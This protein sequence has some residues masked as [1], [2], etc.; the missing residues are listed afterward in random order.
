MVTLCLSVCLKDI[1]SGFIHISRL[2]PSANRDKQFVFNSVFEGSQ[3]FQYSKKSVSARGSGSSSKSRPFITF[4][5]GS[6]RVTQTSP[7]RARACSVSGSSQTKQPAFFF[8]STS[9]ANTSNPDCLNLRPAV[10]LNIADC[11]ALTY[12][13]RSWCG[14]LPPRRIS[15]P[16][17]TLAP[18]NPNRCR[19][20]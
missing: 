4:F 3:R 7:L 13:I 2:S 5:P 9:P 10:R 20:K 12:R 17:P 19:P 15:M 18:S 6:A 8:L 16:R 11:T 1:C 14:A